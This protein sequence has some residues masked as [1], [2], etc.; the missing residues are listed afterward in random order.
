MY[1]EEAGSQPW[2][3]HLWI[4]VILDMLVIGWIQRIVLNAKTKIIEYKLCKHVF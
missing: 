2:Y 3:T 1:N 4:L